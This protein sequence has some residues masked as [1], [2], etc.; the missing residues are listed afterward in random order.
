MPGN[1]AVARAEILL[2]ELPTARTLLTELEKDRSRQAQD[3]EKIFRLAIKHPQYKQ[4]ESWNVNPIAPD[5][6]PLP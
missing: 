2:N 1:E 5:S 3:V 4:M 6:S